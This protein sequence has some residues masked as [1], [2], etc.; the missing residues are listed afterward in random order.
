MS[1]DRGQ[2][3]R[4]KEQSYV[5]ESKERQRQTSGKYKVQTPTLTY[6]NVHVN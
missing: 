4:Y 5:G 1:K 6:C 2:R 3:N